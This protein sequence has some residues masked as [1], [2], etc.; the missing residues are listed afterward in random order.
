MSQQHPDRL[1]RVFLGARETLRQFVSRRIGPEEADDVLQDTWLRLSQHREQEDWREP[2]AMLFATAGNLSIDR[3][4]W[5]QRQQTLV[6]EEA[7]WELCPDERPDPATCLEQRRQVLRLDAALAELPPA[8]RQAFLLNRLEG[9]SHRE[10]AQQLGI[11]CKT[12][13][14][15]IEKALGHCLL[16]LGD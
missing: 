10:I 2:R 12:V 13:Q 14:R 8:C 5:Q 16:R 3:W 1:T 7:G 11:S 4:R 9:L 15:H 6:T